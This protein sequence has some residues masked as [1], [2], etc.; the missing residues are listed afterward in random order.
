LDS[1]FVIIADP[2]RCG[3]DIV[4]TALGDTLDQKGDAVLPRRETIGG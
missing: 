3:G 1:A 2:T 4:L